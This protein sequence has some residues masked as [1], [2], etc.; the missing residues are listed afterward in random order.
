MLIIEDVGGSAIEPAFPIVNLGAN[1]ADST[2]LIDHLVLAHMLAEPKKIDGFRTRPGEEIA[3]TE[4]DMPSQESLRLRT[5]FRGA[6]DLFEL[7]EAPL[8]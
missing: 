1:H 7:A 6:V 8:A 5:R 2:E 4:D 3:F